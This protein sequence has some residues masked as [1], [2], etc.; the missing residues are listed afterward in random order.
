MVMSLQ[1]VKHPFQVMNLDKDVCFEI[2]NMFSAKSLNLCRTA[3]ARQEDVDQWQYLNGIKLPSEIR[4]GEMLIDVDV[5]KAL[6]PHDARKNENGGPYA[7]Q[8]V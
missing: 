1:T 5:P 6:Q 7:I 2:P 3:V 8:T 4:N